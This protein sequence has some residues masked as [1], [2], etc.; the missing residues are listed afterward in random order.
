M[1]RSPARNLLLSLFLIFP[2]LATASDVT[3]GRMTGG[4][5]TIHAD[6]FKESFLE[7]REDVEE[8]AAAGKHVILFMHLNNC[9][10]CYRMNDENFQNA[11]YKSFIQE[12]FDV[13]VINIKGDREVAFDENTSVKEK[14]L[15][16]IL[17]VRYTPTILFL[18]QDNRTVLRL[19]GYRNVTDFK[20]AL[21][22][23][24]QKAYEKTSLSQFIRDRQLPGSYRFRDHPQLKTV[25]DLKSIAAGPV[26]LMF[27]DSNC[28]ACDELHDG[29]LKNPEINAV[30][31]NFTFVRL[32]AD[33]EQQITDL[34]GNRTTAKAY[35]DK[36]GITYR[37]GIVLFDQGRE[38]MR[39]DA[40]LYTYH[41]TEVLRYVGEGH[42]KKYPG[43]FFDYLGVR[44]DSL[45]KAGKDIDL[46][47]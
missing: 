5:Q 31:E 19:D 39:I 17:K 26:A 7:I 44:S 23:V 37:P 40:V 46:S 4:M 15:A 6:W 28:S 10:Y 45:M 33:S 3:P 24:A 8:A 1:R 32:D 22:Y 12:N 35:A 42:Y 47:R 13:I 2:V 29:H 11:P 18:N 41:F 25:S 9:P 21:D 38:I 27:E 34:E 14:E 30:L 43:K 16:E 36:L 20:H